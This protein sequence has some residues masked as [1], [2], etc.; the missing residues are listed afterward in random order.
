MSRTSLALA[1]AL[2]LLPRPGDA[3]GSEQPSAEQLPSGAIYDHAGDSSLTRVVVTCTRGAGGALD[4]DLRTR[5]MVRQ[6]DGRCVV[7]SETASLT[8]SWARPGLWRSV[9]PFAPVLGRGCPEASRRT[10]LQFTPATAR[11]TLT[12]SE[13]MPTKPPP[14][15]A[16]KGSSQAV[17][18]AGDRPEN[19]PPVLEGCG[20]IAAP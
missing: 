6:A 12:I 7:T 1:A 10:E 20:P 14:T 3:A 5:R 19:G 8:L 17:S 13:T 18:R 9:R 11:W 4:C 15:C 16:F 2:A